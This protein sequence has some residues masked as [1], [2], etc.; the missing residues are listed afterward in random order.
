MGDWGNRQVHNVRSRFCEHRLQA[1][2]R[3]RESQLVPERLRFRKLHV[4]DG[5]RLNAGNAAKNFGVRLGDAARSQ[6]GDAEPPWDYLF[7]IRHEAEALA[8]PIERG[9]WQSRIGTARKLQLHQ[10]PDSPVCLRE[11]AC[12]TTRTTLAARRR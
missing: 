3:R 7:V 12:A 10:A 1:R 11:P 9:L 6:Y 2:V 4:A 8:Y 5:D